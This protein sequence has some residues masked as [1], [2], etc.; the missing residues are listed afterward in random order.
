MAARNLEKA[1]EGGD[2]SSIMGAL[3]GIAG[4]IGGF[5][6][7][8]DGAK[9][10]LDSIQ[11]ALNASS[12]FFKVIEAAERGDAEG[13]LSSL[14]NLA[15]AGI[16]LSQIGDKGAPPVKTPSGSNSGGTKN[17]SQWDEW[18]ANLKLLGKAIED[19]LNDPK[20]KPV[21]DFGK[22]YGPEA[23]SFIQALMKENGTG[24]KAGLQWLDGHTGQPKIAPKQQKKQT[25]NAGGSNND[26][27]SADSTDD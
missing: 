1:I 14:V 22:T 27:Q 11:K 26:A 23:V 9:E 24:G 13:I 19:L 25:R 10:I 17:K 21:I 3:V 6:G 20:V 8:T 4:A 16:A 7:L 12:A 2:L 5:D 18:W 15:L